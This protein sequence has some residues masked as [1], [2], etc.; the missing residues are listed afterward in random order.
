MQ[1][2]TLVILLLTPF[3]LQRCTSDSL[4]VTPCTA[5]L[6]THGPQHV[7]YHHGARRHMHVGHCGQ[8]LRGR[9]IVLFP[10]L[11]ELVNLLGQQLVI[12]ALRCSIITP[13]QQ[14]SFAEP[15]TG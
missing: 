14:K 6:E 7:T 13:R 12:L 3:P 11:L 5:T 4:S 1:R 15:R 2:C 8:A 9:V 10:R